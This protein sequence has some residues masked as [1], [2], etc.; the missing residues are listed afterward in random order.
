M[1]NYEFKVNGMK[2]KR[3]SKKAAKKAFNNYHPIFLATSKANLNSIWCYPMAITKNTD[4]DFDKVVNSF[5]YYNCNS[6]MG[7]YA[8]FYIMA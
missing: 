3:I 2:L 8:A 6:E 1:N 4:W 5:E 7:Y